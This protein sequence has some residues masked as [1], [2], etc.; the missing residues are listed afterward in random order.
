MDSVSC[1][2][3]GLDLNIYRHRFISF[4]L[5][6]FVHTQPRLKKALQRICYP[7]RDV[8]ITVL[9][10]PVYINT[11]KELGYWR[12]AR[13][14]YSNVVFR[15]ELSPIMTVS[16][17]IDDATTFVDCGANV[18]VWTCNIA[19]LKPL[20]PNLRV[21]SFE[22]NPDT[23]TRLQKSVSAF[24]NV[25]TFCCALSDSERDLTMF[26]AAGSCAF[27]VEEGPF[28]IKSRSRNIAARPLDSF[29]E[30]IDD[31]VMKVDVE[32]HE[33]EVIRG[34]TATLQ[35]GGI[36]AIYV[37]GFRKDK[38]SRI[39]EC[40]SRGGVGVLLNGRTLHP[41]RSGDYSLLALR[42]NQEANHVSRP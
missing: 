34:A 7:N 28:Q 41:F 26:E 27:G 6:K 9:A 13:G 32:G 22:A 1:S 23:F 21:L 37:D 31:I 3:K 10:A 36:K 11:Q 19:R 40:L 18:G 42:A 39:L 2:I 5:W 17:L 29:L 35:R 24:D 33:L 15:D 25:R 4:L 14:Q 30:G 20:Y 12:A 38:E 8:S 16:S